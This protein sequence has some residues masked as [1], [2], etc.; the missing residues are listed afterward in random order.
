MPAVVET[1]FRIKFIPIE[2]R[3]G[4]FSWWPLALMGS[5]GE[6]ADRD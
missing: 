2:R 3:G 6:R 4:V 5:S 1:P